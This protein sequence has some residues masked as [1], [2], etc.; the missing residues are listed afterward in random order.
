MH[1][2][3]VLPLII[4]LCLLSA[5]ACFAQTT[6]IETITLEISGLK[7][8]VTVRRDGRWI[9]YIEAANAA[10]LHFAQGYVTA[11][12][13]LWQMELYRRVA[14]GETSEIF[15]RAR[16]EE[17][18]RW[19]KFGFARIAEE[20]VR[21]M[22]AEN[23]AL[24]ESYAG[25]VNAYIAT[26]DEKSL[27][28]EFRILQFRPRPWTPADSIVVGKIFDD[29]L[30]NT[31]RIDLIK[32]GLMEIPVE[33]RSRMLDPV[34]PLDVLL[35]GNDAVTAKEPEKNIWKSPV[36]PSDSLFEL[37]AKIEDARRRSLETIG[38][39][40]EDL[41][42]SNNW[43]VSGKRSADG[44]PILADDPHLSPEL[45]SIW[46][47]VNLKLPNM[48]VAGVS[49][50]GIPGVIIGHNE[51]IAWGLTNVGPDV[52]DLYVETF[53]EQG[54]YK[55]P[56]GW[57]APV[58]RREEIKVRKNPLS[59]EI[60]SEF[61]EVV[62]TR[63]GVVFFEEAG[64]RYSL[65]WTAFD[66]KNDTVSA[67]G[68]LSEAR[69]WKEF[70]A[71]LRNYG[72]PMQNFVYAD[73]DGN[74]GWIAAGRVPIRKTGDGSLPYDGSTDDGT[75][76]GMIPF[77]ELPQLYNPPQGFIMT[78]NQRIVGKS[79]KYHNLIARAHTPVRARR[80]QDLLNEKSK[81]T[82]ED[83]KQF[84]YDTF[85]VANSR[86]ARE[87]VN[88][89]AASDETVNLLKNWDGRM[90]ADS[91]AAIVVNSIF[92]AFRNRILSGNFGAERAR[93]M[94]LPYE[95]VFFDRLITE[96]PQDW[97]PKEYS[98]YADLLR[99][100]EK[101]AR[102]NLTKQLGADESKWSWGAA[103]KSR[104]SHP[105]AA[106]PLIGGQFVI[107]PLPQNGAGGWGASPNV[108][109]GV[110]MRF[111]ATPANW[112]ATLHGIPTGQSGNPQSPH[113]KDQLESWYTGNTPVFPFSKPAVEKATTQ[114]WTFQ[115]K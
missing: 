38:F 12:D 5:L 92:T 59:P 90:N 76:T 20:T 77:E 25:G 80:L 36:S 96:K 93:T 6:P 26:L 88:L 39:Y 33:K 14:R 115:P 70:L 18:K 11:S 9:P 60:E 82:I 24:L 47:L 75:W 94:R 40:A 2:K 98:S 1:K 61:L 28:P 7:E 78:A 97:L 87:I 68:K 102:E 54:R 108:G 100:A 95:N 3:I 52:Q 67:F 114:I 17:D 23:R 86:L 103:V 22:T 109:A 65:K 112:D 57:T 53:D 27:P 46:Y 73:R 113:F 34:S 21:N 71:A 55:T 32:A 50:A 41:A 79:Y 48:N 31:W 8:K 10:D 107:E 72:G 49:T 110:S 51:H 99:A 29:G 63:N 84:Q 44:N 101:D 15:G 30:S 69:N 74:I 81:V 13:R 104:F 42:A 64:K 58:T 43:V 85:S 4:L 66:A 105:L 89:Q 83:M 111:I 91:K 106:A 56:T 16:L 62:E 19:R 45:P 37:T 35:V